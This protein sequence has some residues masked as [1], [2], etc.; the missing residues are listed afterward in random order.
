MEGLLVEIVGSDTLQNLHI[1]KCHRSESLP[2]NMHMLLP[3]LKRLSIV[4]CP[5][6]ESFPEGGLPSNLNHMRLNHCSRLVGSL[7]GA[8]RD[9]SSLQSLCIKEVDMESFTE[10]GCF[11]SLLLL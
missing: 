11:H 3:S 7:K 9:S 5:R 2:G 1:I 6:V 8:F 10:E 4:D